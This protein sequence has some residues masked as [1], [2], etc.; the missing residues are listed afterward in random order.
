MARELGTS[1][2]TTTHIEEIEI[3]IQMYALCYVVLCCDRIALLPFIVSVAAGAGSAK[4]G[5]LM[6]ALSAPISIFGGLA[7]GW[8]AGE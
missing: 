2:H 3:Q 7:L 6:A 5:V 1:Q 4:G 8:A